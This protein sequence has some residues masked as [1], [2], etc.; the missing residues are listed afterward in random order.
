MIEGGCIRLQ[1]V[2]SGQVHCTG[3]ES[4]S[5]FSSLREPGQNFV[6]C[7]AQGANPKHEHT[8][9]GQRRSF[10]YERLAP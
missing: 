9:T 8:L 7:S 6:A 3:P 10:Q 2:I 1:G 5:V 4:T